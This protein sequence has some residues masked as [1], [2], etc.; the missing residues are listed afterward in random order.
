MLA[1]GTRLGPY[2][3]L[4][5]L[6]AGGMGEV[7]RA[8]DTKLNRDV[9]IKVLPPDFSARP[10]AVA[11]FER[12][13]K[14]VAALSHP[15]I[16]AIHD[17]G[18]ADRTA[19]AAMELLE[20]Q[21]LRDALADGPLPQRTAIAYAVQMARGL[22]AAHDKEIV[23]RDLKPENVF[24]L[25]DERVKILDFGL[26]RQE[27]ARSDSA[28]L[29]PTIHSPTEAGTI[30]GTVGYMSPE[31]VR[32]T[33]VDARADLFSFGAV[34]YEM[35]AGLRAF[36]RD[37]AAETMT[38]ILREDPPDLPIARGIAPG[39]DRVIR[40]CL[41]KKP[42]ARFRSAHDLAFA[43]ETISGASSSISPSSDVAEQAPRTPISARTRAIAAA[44][45]IAV[46]AGAIGLV[47]GRGGVAS[48]RVDSPSEPPTFK[49]LTFNRGVIGSAR[50][51]AD[52]HTVVYSA[53]WDGNPQ[54]MFLTRPEAPGA[55]PLAFGD[56]TLMDVSPS[57]ELAV[58]LNRQSR[59]T[60]S[61]P[62]TLAQAPML[63][64]APRP[65]IDGVTYADW[66]PTGTGL[67]VV[68]VI[69][70]RERLEFP[71]GHVL[72]E[73]EGQIGFPRVSPSGDRVAFLDWPVKNDDR[74]TVAIVD[75]TGARRT[76][77]RAWEAV[78]GLAWA[79]SGDEVWYT[80]A[81]ET[82]NYTLWGSTLDGRERIIFSAPGGLLIEDVT[83]DGRALMS[84]FDRTALPNV[85][86]AEEPGER[87]IGWLDLSF[88]RDISPDHRRILMSYS[89]AGSGANYDVFVRQ[90][91]TDS[92]TRIGSGQAQQFSPDGKSALSVVHGPPARLQILP[93][94]VGDPIEVKT[95]DLTV[96]EARW[97][98]DG[99]RLVVVGTE[100]NKGLR[101]YVTDMA[102]SIPRAISPEGIT[103]KANQ[104][105]VS[106]DGT[107]VALRSPDG[108]VLLYSTDG[109]EPIGVKGLA[110]GEMPVAWTGDGR[111]VFV[112]VGTPPRGIARLDL[113][114]GR[115]EVVK[116]IRP[117]DPVLIGPI[118]VMPTPDG[119]SYVAN[120][121]RTQTTLFLVEGL[122]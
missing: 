114:S 89:G 7:Y 59:S 45:A 101:A 80:A 60:R 86:F 77:S 107:R 84:R 78:W 115:R 25:A 21:T 17:F 117:A 22:A 103:F 32:A 88:A 111:A 31:Q 105:A 87:A 108:S 13:A 34:L 2:E 5:P 24:I 99:K 16:L 3:I 40:H 38:A 112:P 66:S 48:T 6:G 54:R 1:P 98:P 113:A 29:A 33:A 19:Y 91:D 118:N 65:L 95:A 37:T 43:L 69:G 35:V 62:V 73:T 81:P 93:I 46:A 18:V 71:P 72:F 61:E 82:L 120:Y 75:N 68:H 76:I 12:E 39:L 8:R 15:N 53:A 90:F 20:G 52:G 41:E 49:Q 14:A 47:I 4:A 106:P 10:D 26:A 97:M 85:W 64:G 110:A 28:T 58:G 121:D 42:E 104:L 23:H 102:G 92:V 122:R 63:G 116:D 109:A 30:L 27:P 44:L 56:A 74:G 67:A 55:T 11:R 57:S 100:P 9:A 119:R 96:T 50:F 94:G 83:K 36:H 79:P 51:T 70:S